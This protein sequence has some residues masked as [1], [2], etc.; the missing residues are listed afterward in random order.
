MQANTY[1]V[2]EVDINDFPNDGDSKSCRMYLMVLAYS[3]HRFQSYLVNLYCTDF[4]ENIYGTLPRINFDSCINRDGDAIAP[5]KVIA[6]EIPDS[7]IGSFLNEHNLP[8]PQAS[9]Y[10]DVYSKKVLVEI[11]GTLKRYRN[12][13]DF[14]RGVVHTLT[15]TDIIK[16]VRLNR[17]EHLINT[18]TLLQKN[19]PLSWKM[20]LYEKYGLNEIVDDIGPF[21]SQTQ[22]FITQN[23]PS[24]SQPPTH[25]QPSRSFRLLN[26]MPKPTSG[27][28][29]SVP[30]SIKDITRRMLKTEAV[31]PK[32]DYTTGSQVSSISSQSQPSS[33]NGHDSHRGLNTINATSITKDSRRRR[34]DD[35]SN[36]V[37]SVGYSFGEED[38]NFIVTDPYT[39]KLQFL[40]TFEVYI[41]LDSNS[42]TI[43]TLGFKTP[44]A[45]C[46]FIL[47]TEVVASIDESNSPTK[48]DLD[49]KF[50]QK[51][52]TID[53]NVLL[54]FRGGADE[55]YI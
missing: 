52:I 10:F 47:G 43:H 38:N 3:T 33:H 24:V 54:L 50:Q 11:T 39:Q 2:E 51:P 42:N 21:T 46:R 29:D 15:K 17:D 41:K 5:E 48:D 9:P 31:S 1:S 35:D 44:E 27:N 25:Q 4:T 20:D 7:Q 34:R 6:F 8:E 30:D 55:V 53:P 49:E 26:E 18:L 37:F 19:C 32:R 40:D 13:I 36:T 45:V 22:E 14:R 12:G 23:A 16:R 28:D